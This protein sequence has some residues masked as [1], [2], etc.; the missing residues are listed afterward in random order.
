MKY[1]SPFELVRYAWCLPR[2]RVP[3]VTHVCHQ[4]HQKLL[5]Y[6]KAGIFS[7]QYDFIYISALVL[8]PTQAGTKNLPLPGRNLEQD[9]AAAANI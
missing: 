1:S 4:K 3:P 7:I 6:D 5:L 8:T 2:S 9:Q